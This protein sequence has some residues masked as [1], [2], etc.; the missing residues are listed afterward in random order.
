MV[1]FL[2]RRADRQDAPLLNLAIDPPLRKNV[3]RFENLKYPRAAQ[4]PNVLVR[5]YR[6]TPV[7]ITY[8]IFAFSHGAHV[9]RTIHW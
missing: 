5:V 7:E 8:K 9:W 1:S 4:H 6:L 3:I 2:F